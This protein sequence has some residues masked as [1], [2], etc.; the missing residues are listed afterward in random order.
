MRRLLVGTTGPAGAQGI[1][2]IQGLTGPVA[3]GLAGKKI[4]SGTFTGP[5]SYSTGG[6]VVDL[7]G[8]FATIDWVGLT[9]EVAGALLPPSIVEVTPNNSSAGKIKVR[10]VTA[11]NTELL[12]TTNL[13][14]ATFRYLGLGT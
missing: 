12:A 11:A 13:S 3:S 8:T 1:Q 10:L 9:V 4:G 7:T 2:G 14:G 6:F 5:A